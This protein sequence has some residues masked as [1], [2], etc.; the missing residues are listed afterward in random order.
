MDEKIRIID[1]RS[2]SKF[3]IDDEY[4]NGYARLCGIYA[5]GVYVSLCRHADR[6]QY[7]FPG[8]ELIAQELNV[9]TKSV[10]RAIKKLRSWGI[11]KIQKRKRKK[12]MWKNNSYILLDKSIWKPKP[13]QEA[14][15]LLDTNQRTYIPDPSDCETFDQGTDSLIKE[16]NNEGNKLKE[17]HIPAQSAENKIMDIFLS[18]NPAL[19][20]KS[21]Y[22]KNAVKKMIEIF[23]FEEVENFCKKTLNE[24]GKEFMPIITTPTEMLSKWVKMKKYF[25]KKE[26]SGILGEDD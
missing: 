21:K 1:Q 18:K 13:I 11:I 3:I 24:K 16:A 15:S 10:Q 23:G 9:S 17:T 7:C 19:N 26:T 22:Q 14:D 4:L 2:K 6:D 20:P 8:E 5:T 25:E 12:G